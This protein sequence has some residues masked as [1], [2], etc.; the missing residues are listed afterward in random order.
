M[1][2]IAVLPLMVAGAT[3]FVHPGLLHTKE[4]FTRVKEFVDQK[5]EPW[6]T[7]WNLLTSNS[8]A[9]TTY[10]PRPAETVYRGSDGVHSQNYSVLYN[11]AHAAYQ[12]A[13]RW[14]ISGSSEYAD[15][16]IRILDEW[17]STMKAIGGNSDGFLAAGLYG[18]QLA[19]AGEIMRDYSGWPEANRARLGDLLQNVF[20]KDSYRFLT[21][22]NDASKYHYWANWDLCS[23]AAIQA[24]GVFTDNQTMYDYA[25]N[26]FIAGDG[27][28]AMP[29]FIVANHTE[30]GSG[31]ILA[32]SQEAG[33]DQGHATL[34]IALLG[35]ILQQGYNQG[36]D[37]F[38]LM[39]NSGLAA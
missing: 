19:N 34:D 4:D 35:V 1:V 16:A 13:L 17:S 18:Y 29:N 30:E 31:K 7:T 23:I 2:Q 36:N 20:Y 39:S 32:Q 14:K 3:A 15:A 12:L 21:T 25:T 26:Y 9:S 11:D 22:H 24:I 38:A 8:H 28:G 10:T 33:R 5:K 27:M 6:L 37:L